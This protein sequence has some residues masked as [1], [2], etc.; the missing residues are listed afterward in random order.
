MKQIESM[1]AHKLVV[2]VHLLDEG[3][4]VIAFYAYTAEWLLRVSGVKE[5]LEASCP[6]FA[7]SSSSSAP[8]SSLKAFEALSQAKPPVEFCC[9]PEF[10]IENM[11]DYFL[12]VWRTTPHLL[13]HSSYMAPVIELFVL[14]MGTSNY[15]RN[16]YLRSKLAE[17]LYLLSCADEEQ[18]GMASLGAV[19]KGL[20]LFF[21]NH[22]V[23]KQF[24]VPALLSLYVDIETTGR[25]GQF[26]EKF[27]VRRNISVLLKHLRTLPHYRSAL[28]DQSRHNL[29]FF[30]RFI[31]RLLDDSNYLM[32]EVMGKVGEA[33]DLEAQINDQARWRGM[34]RQQQQEVTERLSEVL[35]SAHAYSRFAGEVIHLLHSLSEVNIEPFVRPEVIDRM[36]V[37][38]NYFL[39]KLVG[40][41]AVSI[42][43]KAEGKLFVHPN[44]LLKQV[45]VFYFCFVLFCFVLFCFVLFCFV[46]VWFGLLL[47]IDIFGLPFFRFVKFICFTIWTRILLPLLPLMAVRFR[48]SYSKTLPKKQK[49]G[50]FSFY[51]FKSTQFPSPPP[52]PKKKTIIIIIIII[53]ANNNNN[54]N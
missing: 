11:A 14:F 5:H 22:Q 2:D 20:W 42:S 39:A 30:L 45:F 15:I 32:D 28:N 21:E 19:G 52:P 49:N 6:G 16:P 26:Y 40:K 1:Q 36:A 53:I 35:N 4:N 7:P 51:F 43:S 41:S 10:I 34:T 27:F 23:A 37:M 13:L 3:A 54:N 47:L 12:F 25:D 44:V 38:L 50:F 24:L 46:L 29:S 9:I 48:L 18:G 31:H 8:L 17:V 33:S